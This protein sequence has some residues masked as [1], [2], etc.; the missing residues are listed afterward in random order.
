MLPLFA[1]HQVTSPSTLRNIAYHMS[2][3][4]GF[5]SLLHLILHYIEQF[6]KTFFFLFFCLCPQFLGVPKHRDVVNLSYVQVTQ[7]PFHLELAN[8]F[9]FSFLSPL[10][11]KFNL[12]SV[13]LYRSFSRGK[14]ERT[15]KLRYKVIGKQ[16]SIQALLSRGHFR[17]LDVSQKLQQGLYK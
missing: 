16:Y 15:M 17:I 9:R 10:Y 1:P 8:L 14:E 4:L 12:F 5:L 2:C 6:C 3:L 7:T 11:S 13:S